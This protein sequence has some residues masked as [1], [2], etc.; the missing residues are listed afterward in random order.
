MIKK[1]ELSGIHIDIDENIKKYVSLIVDKLESYIP[2]QARESAHVEVKLREFKKQG[3]KPY[4]AEIIIK[5]PQ[6]TLTAKET[7]TDLFAA[8]DMVEAKMLQQLKKYKDTHTNPHFY[9]HITNKFR[10]RSS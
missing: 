5:L 8:I 2:K 6:D 7:N 10:R 1:F 9:R 3:G 4:A